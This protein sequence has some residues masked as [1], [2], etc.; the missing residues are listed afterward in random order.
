M[1]NIAEP[2]IHADLR[3]GRTPI[4]RCCA[5]S[6]RTVLYDYDPAFQMIY[7]KVVEKA[8]KAMRLSNPPVI[9]HG[10]PVLGL[11]AAAASLIAPRRRRAQPCLRRLRQGL[12]LLGEALLR[13][14]CVE[15]EVALQRGDRSAGGRRAC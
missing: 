6:S 14:S 2:V 8:Q 3:A 11:E 10:E 7:E 4:R 13:R 1:P 9:L 15:I 12:W 5:A